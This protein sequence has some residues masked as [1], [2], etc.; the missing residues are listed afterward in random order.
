MILLLQNSCMSSG[1][2]QTRVNLYHFLEKEKE[3]WHIGILDFHMHC[4]IELPYKAL[5]ANHLTGHNR[6]RILTRGSNNIPVDRLD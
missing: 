3:T 1:H 2:K 4:H 6:I 5:T